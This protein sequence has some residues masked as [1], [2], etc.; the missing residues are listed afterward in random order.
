M[1]KKVVKKKKAV[2]KVAEAAPVSCSLEKSDMVLCKFSLIAAIFFIMS[3]W[4]ALN[5]WVVGVSPWIWLVL[6][7][8]LG[9]KPMMK[10]CKK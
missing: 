2:K 9:W 1:A 7:V 4:G 8:V 6:A 10:Q 3:L 5:T